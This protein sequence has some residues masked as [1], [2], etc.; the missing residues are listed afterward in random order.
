M[1]VRVADGVSGMLMQEYIAEL[2][3]PRM[4][5]RVTGASAQADPRRPGENEDVTETETNEKEHT[6]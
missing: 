3:Q 6:V 1:D 2:V 4:V 5:A